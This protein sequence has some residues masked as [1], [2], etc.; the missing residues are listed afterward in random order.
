MDL[1]YKQFKILIIWN[2]FFKF[3]RHYRKWSWASKWDKYCDFS[4]MKF[5]IIN[6]EII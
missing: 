1:K 3:K 6:F 5:W 2:F 4:N